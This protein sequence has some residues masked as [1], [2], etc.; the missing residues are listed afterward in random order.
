MYQDVLFYS[1]LNEIVIFTLKY[2]YIYIYIQYLYPN[3]PKKMDH[4]KIL[5]LIY[6]MQD[7]RSTCDL[8]HRSTYLELNS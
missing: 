7:T 6:I 5:V 1:H 3:V 8:V 2:I 4:F